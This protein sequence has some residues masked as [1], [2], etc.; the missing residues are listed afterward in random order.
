M[1]WRSFSRG[2][3]I[4]YT[5]TSRARTS[6]VTTS[7]ISSVR[8]YRKD[9]LRDIMFPESGRSISANQGEETV[10]QSKHVKV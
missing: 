4:I 7:W 8:D 2:L 1:S 3:R 9:K 5:P 10:V 6:S